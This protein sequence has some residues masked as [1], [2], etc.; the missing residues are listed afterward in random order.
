MK[1]TIIL[2]PV[3]HDSSP[4]VGNYIVGLQKPMSYPPPPQ[5][6]MKKATTT[7]TRVGVRK[8]EFFLLASQLLLMELATHPRSFSQL[9]ISHKIVGFD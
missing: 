7:S 4:T 6:A 3:T 1:Y 2:Y 5:W 9:W 8:N